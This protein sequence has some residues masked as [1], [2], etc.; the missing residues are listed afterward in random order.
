[1][2]MAD[3][4]E[5][6]TRECPDDY[7]SAENQRERERAVMEDRRRRAMRI[8]RCQAITLKGTQCWCEEGKY[9][10]VLS[11]DGFCTHHQ[12]DMYKKPKEQRV[13]LLG[14]CDL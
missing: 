9:G 12:D 4:C 14:P 1:M 8:G 7:Y 3:L 13:K 2:Y 5:K 11:E 10:M 6:Q